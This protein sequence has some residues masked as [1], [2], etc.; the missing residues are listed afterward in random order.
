MRIASS[1]NITYGSIKEHSNTPLVILK[2]KFTLD[3]GLQLAKAVDLG[4]R[5]E[6]FWVES[7]ASSHRLNI[8]NVRRSGEI[9]SRTDWPE[10]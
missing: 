2:I 7:K 4:S 1:R 5:L 6:E 9:T 10:G 8:I 3:K